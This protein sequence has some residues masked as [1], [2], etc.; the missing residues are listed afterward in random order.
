MTLNST[1]GIISDIV[2]RVLPIAK[3]AGVKIRK[4]DLV[5]SV[6]CCHFNIYRL[7]LVEMS[8]A[9]LGDVAHDVFG[10]HKYLD[11]DTMTLTQCFVPRFGV[12][13]VTPPIEQA[14]RR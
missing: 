10:I 13:K 8:K 1:P 11:V 7:D 2:D 9:D 5:L 3:A 6:T 14:S 12:E 4:Q